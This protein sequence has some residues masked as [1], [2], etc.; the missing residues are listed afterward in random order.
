MNYGA[1]RC[2]ELVKT[3]TIEFNIKKVFDFYLSLKHTKHTR[4][5]LNHIYQHQILAS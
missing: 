3:I 5:G 4:R 1:Y 2:Y